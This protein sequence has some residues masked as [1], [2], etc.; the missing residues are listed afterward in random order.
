MYS[1]GAVTLWWW[2][3]SWN[4]FTF[5]MYYC[6]GLLSGK[7]TVIYPHP[8]VAKQSPKHPVQSMSLLVISRVGATRPSQEVWPKFSH[9]GCT[10]AVSTVT[11]TMENWDLWVVPVTT[12]MVREIFYCVNT[13]IN[14]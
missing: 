7:V 5:V 12:G 9:T 6:P 10:Q 3:Q 14:L 1:V 2:T 13:V 11:I 4:N 8:Q